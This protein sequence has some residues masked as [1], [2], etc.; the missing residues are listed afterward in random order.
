MNRFLLKQLLFWKHRRQ[1][2]RFYWCV[3]HQRHQVRLSQ[4]ILCGSLQIDVTQKQNYIL[5]D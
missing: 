1:Y 5:F 2:Y 3:S 4:C